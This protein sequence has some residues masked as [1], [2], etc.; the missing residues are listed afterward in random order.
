MILKLIAC[1]QHGIMIGEPILSTKSPLPELSG[2]NNITSTM[3]TSQQQHQPVPDIET[4]T[5]ENRLKYM[6]LF[7]SFN[8]VNN[9]LN[10]DTA[11]DIFMRSGLS[12]AVLQKIWD[13]ADT[14]RTGSLN[15]TEFIIAMH[16]VEMAMKGGG[17]PSLLPSTLPATVYASAT[18][19]NNTGSKSAPPPLSSP[20]ARKNTMLH[21]SPTPP[22]AA[23]SPIFKGAP[24]MT[25]LSITQ[26]EFKKYHTFFSRLDTD[27]VGFVSGADAVVF[28]RHSKLPEADLA[29]IWDLAD[30]NSSGKLTEKEFALAMHL[31]NRRIA[32]HDIPNSIS[33]SNFESAFKSLTTEQ[34]SK[35][36]QQNID[37]LGLT[38]EPISYNKQLAE[39]S[40]QQFLTQDISELNRTRSLLQNDISK[41]TS[42]L[43]SA[44]QQLSQI[45]SQIR[46]LLKSI[47]E[48]KVQL[49]KIKQ[50]A[51]EAERQ[52]EA[53][54]Q[55]KEE[56]SKEL[57]MYKQEVKHYTLRLDDTK[58]ELESLQQNGEQQQYSHDHDPE[59]MFT[60][61][62]T[63]NSQ[64]T[65]NN[66]FAKVNR[67]SSNSNN[68]QQQ[69]LAHLTA[70]ISPTL[71]QQFTGSSTRSQQSPQQRDRNLD[72][73]AGFKKE[74]PSPTVSMN[75]LKEQEEKKKISSSLMSSSSDGPITTDISYIESKF[76]D[77]STM[78]QNFA[79]TT[80]S[81]Q[82]SPQ[83]PTSSP[84]PSASISENGKGPK[85]L[86]DIFATSGN[87]LINNESTM[88]KST[89]IKS[90]SK[91]DILSAFD[92]S[93]S[94]TFDK[95]KISSTSSV[96]DEL[97][98][99]FSPKISNT[100]IAQQQLE[101][102]QQKVDGTNFNDIFGG[103]GSENN[104]NDSN[105]DT[106]H[107]TSFEDVFFK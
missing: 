13:L 11:R 66:L 69:P 88:K 25:N 77:L 85:P 16:Y 98:S 55:K 70:A 103:G 50:A 8:P 52:L 20:I 57:Q 80:T 86:N 1:A 3:Q 9:S 2:N 65:G 42:R 84:Q 46:D 91:L 62:S 43:Q 33:T 60:L 63:V 26:D 24:A 15:Q 74:S 81:S 14:R 37:L 34:Q 87:T 92:P 40:Q 102:N 7:Q 58:E 23:K 36:P 89:P 45:S 39:E 44:Q 53:E 99:I 47:E 96:Q 59:N 68:E 79:V 35:Q 72:P 75:K 4:I 31:I 64:N 48:E 101:S 51:D 78:E 71:K 30:T 95:N 100:T 82:T 10:G 29:K 54:K 19:R 5:P 106:S 41:E 6:N 107:P 73:F 93:S 83:L 28:F 67:D 12:T 90:N 38:A 56:L 76:P 17:N 49:A 61:S 94:S 18:G 32:G 21:S 22:N 104:K 97:S 105:V 27:G